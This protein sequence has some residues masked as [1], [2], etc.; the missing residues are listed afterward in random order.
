[1]V[2]Y[3]VISLHGKALIEPENEVG[4]LIIKD[5]TSFGVK[6][7]PISNQVCITFLVFMMSVV[8][9]CFITIQR[10]YKT[11]TSID[12]EEA[13]KTILLLW[14]SSLLSRTGFETTFSDS[15]A[16]H[17]FNYIMFPYIVVLCYWQFSILLLYVCKYFLKFHLDCK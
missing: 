14:I 10:R 13:E 3:R 17:V 8:S 11:L 1:M 2:E 9:I 16:M 6:R 15:N 7:V 4:F 12:C 5:G